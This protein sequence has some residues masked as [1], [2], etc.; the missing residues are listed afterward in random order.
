MAGVS[1]KTPCVVRKHQGAGS[2]HLGP[3]FKLLPGCPLFFFICYFFLS[4]LFLAASLNRNASD[5]QARVVFERCLHSALP[6]SV[7]LE[8]TR[9]MFCVCLRCRARTRLQPL[10]GRVVWR[11]PVRLPQNES[12]GCYIRGM[13]RRDGSLELLLE[14]T[15]ASV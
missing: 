10:Y 3:A 15:H 9:E 13:G 12:E 8:P 6:T 4:W 14:H 1:E 11:E 7:T 5:R 2:A